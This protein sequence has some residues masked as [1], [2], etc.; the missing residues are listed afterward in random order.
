MR[1]R[2]RSTATPSTKF[3]GR[4]TVYRATVLRFSSPTG[5]RRS[6]APTK[7]SC[8]IRAGSPNA[9]RMPSFWQVAAF[10][11]VCGIGSERPRRH[12]KNW[13]GWM[14]TRRTVRRRLTMSS[15]L[16]PPNDDRLT[17][18]SEFP[19]PLVGEGGST[20]VEPGE[21]M[22]RRQAKALRAN[23][24]D[25]ERRLWYLLRAHRFKGIK[26]KRQAVIG[27]YIVD[28]ASFERRLVIEVDG[29][30]HA[31]NEADL[32]GDRWLEHQGFRI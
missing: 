4:S 27:R 16:K 24:T 22:T 6:L 7:S 25:A 14:T 15:P 10:M 13:R 21:G 17:T 31:D 19:S 11:P 30:Q 8:S 2:R 1:Q 3:R 20:L 28:F 29:G 32:R 18:G 9:G 12:G 23:L 26:F 5:C